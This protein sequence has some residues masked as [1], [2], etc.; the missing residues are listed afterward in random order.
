MNLQTASLDRRWVRAAFT[1]AALL[2]AGASSA[3]AQSSVRLYGIVDA[4]VRYD[5]AGP[6][7]R[8][9]LASDYG[10]NFKD[11]AASTPL[12]LAGALPVPAG[13]D[14]SAFAVG[15]RLSC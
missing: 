8:I 7:S 4:Q 15:T 6:N 11:A 1:A 5:R 12:Y 2:A 14:P 13:A 10:R 9:S 3:F